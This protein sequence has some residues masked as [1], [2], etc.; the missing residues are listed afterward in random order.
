[1]V[2]SGPHKSSVMMVVGSSVICEAKIQRWLMW[3]AAVV[4]SIYV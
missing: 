4:R 1:L 2:V 3:H